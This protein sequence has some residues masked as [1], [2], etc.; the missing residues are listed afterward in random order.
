[1]S[2]STLGRE[3]R[4]PEWLDSAELNSMGAALHPNPSIEPLSSMG[5]FRRLLH[6]CFPSPSPTP[7]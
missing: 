1:M 7:R 3:G 2:L 4:D 5:P 6:L